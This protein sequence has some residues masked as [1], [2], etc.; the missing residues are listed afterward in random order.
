MLQASP[1]QETGLTAA[2]S[3]GLANPDISCTVTTGTAHDH[4]SRTGSGNVAFSP[5]PPA[6]N[7]S[8]RDTSGA[9]GRKACTVR[10]VST[11]GCVPARP[12]PNLPMSAYPAATRYSVDPEAELPFSSGAG[13][14]AACAFVIRRVCG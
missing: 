13:W 14:V 2:V 8:K 7:P 11:R 9:R 12:R 5:D 6:M 1:A 3:R 10:T 4:L